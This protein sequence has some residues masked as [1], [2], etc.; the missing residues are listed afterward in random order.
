[1]NLA[2]KVKSHEKGMTKAAKAMGL[3]KKCGSISESIAARRSHFEGVRLTDDIPD[4]FTTK[5][6]DRLGPTSIGMY[7]VVGPKSALGSIPTHGGNP[8]QTDSFAG[9]SRRP[10]RAR[11]MRYSK[12]GLQPSR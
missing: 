12:R 5:R 6:L 3:Q 1:M 4:I 11:G 2:A 9:K 10:R 7:R 8:H